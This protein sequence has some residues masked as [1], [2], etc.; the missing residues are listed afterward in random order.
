VLGII[1][2]SGVYDVPWL[3][4]P[5]EEIV[6]NKYGE[7]VIK[8]GWLENFEVAFLTRH[9]KGHKTSPSLINYRANLMALSDFGVTDIIATYAVGGISP[10]M[11]PGDFAILDQFIDFTKNRIGTFYNE[12]GKVVHTDVSRP[13]SPKLQE[14]IE[15]ALIKEHAVFHPDS[16]YVCTEGPRY[17][18]PAEIKAFSIMGATI[19]GMT[20]CPE[21][22]LAN[23]LGIAFGGIAIVTNLAAGVAKKPLGHKEVMDTFNTRIEQ[24][25]NILVTI[26]KLASQEPSTT[27]TPESMSA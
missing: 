25:S 21:V 16:V 14:F 23:E 20:G 3:D 6:K 11:V 26:A 5:K 10:K 8:S 19:V 13:Y 9:G 1:G 27:N 17:E 4:D 18:T 2:G 7:A 22:A 15:E 12:P 24:L